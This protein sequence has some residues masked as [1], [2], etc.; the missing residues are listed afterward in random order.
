MINGPCPPV[1]VHVFKV[2]VW[3]V[4]NSRYQNLYSECFWQ[5]H[6]EQERSSPSKEW[7]MP[8]AEIMAQGLHVGVCC[9]CL[10]IFQWMKC[11][12][13]AFHFM[14]LFSFVFYICWKGETIIILGGY[15]ERYPKG[16]WTQLHQWLGEAWWYRGSM[17]DVR[18]KMNYLQMHR[19]IKA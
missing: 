3:N 12:L 1:N 16:Y 9:V 6:R 11:L 10:L 15:P 14:L 4:R 2:K 13:Q 19:L 5:G 8:K 17:E 18:G 7:T